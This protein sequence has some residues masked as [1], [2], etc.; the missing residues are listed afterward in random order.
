MDPSG[1]PDGTSDWLPVDESR[2]SAD[3]CSPIACVA[4]CDTTPTPPALVAGFDLAADG[5]GEVTAGVFGGVCSADGDL[6]ITGGVVV[7]LDAAAGVGLVAVAGFLESIADAAA[8]AFFESTGGVEVAESGGETVAEES[9]E[10]TVTS[11]PPPTPS[12]AGSSSHFKSL[13]VEVTVAVAVVG[14]GFAAGAASGFGADAIAGGAV[15]AASREY[16][17]CR[18]H[19]SIQDITTQSVHPER[20]FS[21]FYTTHTGARE[22]ATAVH[23]RNTASK[24]WIRRPNRQPQA[25]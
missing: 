4:A 7:P 18:L 16:K 20:A 11:S 14:A 10:N 1:E 3:G 22:P 17:R 9:A 24:I 15:S 8:P 5:G 13:F 21:P 12:L 23:D 19:S 6:L 25:S 2:V